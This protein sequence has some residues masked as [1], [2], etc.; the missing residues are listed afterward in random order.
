MSK[1]IWVYFTKDYTLNYG[2]IS[3]VYKVTSKKNGKKYAL[4]EVV[5]SQ[6]K[7]SKYFIQQYEEIK[8]LN[9]ERIMKIKTIIYPDYY[10][11]LMEICPYSLEEYI[12]KF[13]SPISIEDIKEIFIQINE[14]LKQIKAKN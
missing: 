14:G 11:I 5:K 13:D 9:S 1:N 4:K 8:K 7:D 3:K 10:Y 2:P 6:L 12:Q